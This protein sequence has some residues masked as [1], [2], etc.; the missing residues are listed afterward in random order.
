MKIKRADLLGLRKEVSYELKDVV[1]T[2]EDNPYIR[3]FH[4]KKGEF[5]LRPDSQED[6]D[7]YYTLDG[8]MI[9]PCAVSLE[10]VSVPLKRE[11]EIK[12]CFFERDDESYFVSNDLDFIAFIKEM[13]EYEAPLKVTKSE[14]MAYPEGD[15]W[16][17]MS[18]EDYQTQKANRPNALWEK[19]KDYKFDKED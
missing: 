10:D 15:G 9:C 12:V 11:D 14:E 2:Y 1:V 16:R 7:M 5:V 3:R 8:E 4:L 13:V 18:E 6:L 17:L 19:L